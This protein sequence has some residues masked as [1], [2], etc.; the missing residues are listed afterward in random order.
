[1]S[2]DLGD[3][4]PREA[5]RQEDV[6]LNPDHGRPGDFE[7]YALIAALTLVVLGLLVWDRWHEREGPP[8]P[9]PDRALRIRIGGTSSPAA[10]AAIGP[11]PPRRPTSTPTQST[12]DPPP[13]PAP[14]PRTVVMRSG[15]TLYDIARRELGSAARAQEIADLNGI[16]DPGRV[17]IG[18]VL[19]LPAK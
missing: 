14:A 1:M 2:G 8:P 3:V 15:D 7:R 17:R 18:Q 13:P 11:E 6:V 4:E 9:S 5:A 10:Q 19:K 16:S 12:A